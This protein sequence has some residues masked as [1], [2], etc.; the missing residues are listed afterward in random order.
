MHVLVPSGSLTYPFLVSGGSFWDVD[1]SHQMYGYFPCLFDGSYSLA[2]IDNYFK[3]TKGREYNNVSHCKPKG[4]SDSPFLPFFDNGKWFPGGFH[5]TWS[6][7]DQVRNGG[8]TGCFSRTRDGYVYCGIASASGGTSSSTLR[9]GAWGKRY[10][11]DYSYTHPNYVYYRTISASVQVQII[12]DHRTGISS[13]SIYSGNTFIRGTVGAEMAT[14]LIG[15][16]AGRNLLDLQANVNAAIGA[17]TIGAMKSF[18]VD[19]ELLWNNAHCSISSVQYLRKSDCR[20]LDKPSLPSFDESTSLFYEGSVF[21]EGVDPIVVQGKSGRHYW[22][23]YLIQHAYFDAVQNVPRLNE[24]SISNIL[25]IAEFISNL[26]VRHRVEVPKSLSAAWLSYRYQYC[27]TKMDVEEA[28]KFVHRHMDL[29]GVDEITSYGRSSADVD[30][31]TVNCQCC[32]HI[33]PREVGTLGSIWRALY[34]YGLQPNFYVVWDMIPYSFIVDWLLPVGKLAGVLDAERMYSG[35]YYDIS[36]VQFSLSY[37]RKDENTGITRH[38]YTRWY[39]GTPPQLNGLYF[40]ENDQAS[41]RTIG[42]RALD[43]LSLF[44]G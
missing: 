39:Q 8:P 3:C 11:R 33:K 15:V 27:T 26:V 16:E 32:F 21:L 18:M 43:S 14:G 40:L 5:N 17:Q 10:V 24:N 36:D 9:Y 25:E 19:E 13:V 35:T 41:G 42:M 23:N 30:G 31:S 4:L 2:E 29:Q 6:H 37:D 38:W 28:I 12:G 7:P 22:R 1:P 44:I 34:T 20:R